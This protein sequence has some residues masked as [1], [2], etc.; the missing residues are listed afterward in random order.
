MQ[1]NPLSGVSS[2]PI[3]ATQPLAASGADFEAM[4]RSAME[5]TNGAQTQADATLEGLI[6]GK[7]DNVHE[8]VLGLAKAEMSFNFMME[9]R[10][11]VVDTYHDLMRMQV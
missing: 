2:G 10:N 8:V 7:T 6:M 5:A 4:L 9:V 1:I 3:G 11:R